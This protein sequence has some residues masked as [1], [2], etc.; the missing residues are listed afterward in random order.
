MP[1][2]DMG[3]LKR[4]LA[5]YANRRKSMRKRKRAGEEIRRRFPPL[6]RAG[7]YARTLREPDL[8][9]QARWM[10][11]LILNYVGNEEAANG[12]KAF[13]YDPNAPTYLKLDAATILVRIKPDVKLEPSVHLPAFPERWLEQALALTPFF[14]EAVRRNFVIQELLFDFFG[15]GEE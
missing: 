3:R 5:T 10:V 15:Q 11:M 4:L 12:L 1:F 9:D 14:S 6:H 7:L 8:S 13:L 2:T